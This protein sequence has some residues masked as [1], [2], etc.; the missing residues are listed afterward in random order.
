MPAGILPYDVT[1]PYETLLKSLEDAAIKANCGFTKVTDPLLEC[2]TRQDDGTT[3]FNCFVHLQDWK[4]RKQRLHILLHVQETIG[5]KPDYRLERSTV[6]VNYFKV[7]EG[8]AQLLQSIH[9]DFGPSQHRHPVFHAQLTNECVSLS[10]EVAAQLEFG[11]RQL[12]CATCFKE[13]RIPTSDMTLP[14]VLLCLAADHFESE[15]EPFFDTVLELQKT[16]PQPVFE[17]TRASLQ[18]TPDFRVFFIRQ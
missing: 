10:E 12:P 4:A 6:R 18:T 7:S 2:F 11:F 8:N 14:S 1:G 5:Q 16:L 17:K 9:F 15:F 3:I 13:A